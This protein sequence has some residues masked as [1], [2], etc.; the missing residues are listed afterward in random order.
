VELKVI[1]SKPSVII[2]LRDNYKNPP[3]F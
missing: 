2:Y 1:T 3:K